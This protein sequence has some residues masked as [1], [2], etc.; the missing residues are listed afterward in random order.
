MSLSAEQK[1]YYLNV[2][3]RTG[4]LKKSFAQ[5]DIP[6]WYTDYKDKVTHEE[7]FLPTS[8]GDVRCVVSR[9][10]EREND[11][12]AFIHIH[13]GG[14]FFPQNGDDDLF[15][16][17]VAA[18]TKGVVVD[19]D[20]ATSLEHPFPAAVEQCREVCR[21]IFE[22]AES[23]GV[24]PERVSIGGDS[25]G[26]NL[27]A[28]MTQSGE[29]DFAMQVLDYAA[30]D[31]T[32]SGGDKNAP[33]TLSSERLEAFNVFYMD[34]NMELAKS[35]LVS[36]GRAEDDTLKKQPAT[37]MVTAG[38]CPFCGDN[39]AYA[40]LLVSLGI[41]VAMRRFTESRHGF[42]IRL[43]DEWD[44]AQKFIISHLKRT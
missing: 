29:F 40:N 11:C 31:M 30:L 34:G 7:V 44:S 27:T 14:F 17:R 1:Q 23:L 41:E 33:L 4:S 39:E 8:H 24:S 10:N 26:G 32:K 6:A 16:A 19:I 18:E 22:N 42:T 9:A 43:V 21:W 13:G 3:E 2:L 35:P 38:H 36:P 37:V 5:R 28:V 25:A 12:R 20:Y 15:C